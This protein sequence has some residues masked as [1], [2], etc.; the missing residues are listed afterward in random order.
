[1]PKFLR[2]MKRFVESCWIF[3][4]NMAFFVVCIP[5]KTKIDSTITKIFITWFEEGHEEIYWTWCWRTHLLSLKPY[6]FLYHATIYNAI[7]ITIASY[8]YKLKIQK[9]WYKLVNGATFSF[10]INPIFQTI[11]SCSK[12]RFDVIFNDVLVQVGE[13]PTSDE[14]SRV[15]VGF[16]IKVK[17]FWHDIVGVKTKAKLSRSELLPAIIIIMAFGVAKVTQMMSAI[18]LF[19]KAS[20]STLPLLGIVRVDSK[21]SKTVWR[22]HWFHFEVSAYNQYQKC[23]YFIAKMPIDWICIIVF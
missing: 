4:F 6:H 13:T 8:L 12:G 9:L 17:V 20:W 11:P 21:M 5:D 15:I 2:D 23:H 14:L 16:P 18:R 10:H 22:F 7:I 1:M 3:R 19:C